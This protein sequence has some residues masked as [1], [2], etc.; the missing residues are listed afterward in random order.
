MFISHL[1]AIFILFYNHLNRISSYFAFSLQ[2]KYA[3]I[4]LSLF[5]AIIAALSKKHVYLLKGHHI[6]CSLFTWLVHLND[7]LSPSPVSNGKNPAT[8]L[9]SQ[10]QFTFRIVHLLSPFLLLFPNLSYHQ[11]HITTKL[12]KSN[13]SR[14]RIKS[15]NHLSFFSFLNPPDP[16]IPNQ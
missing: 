6:T 11:H 2:T 5:P 14:N 12:N 13:R 9:M 3:Y 10:S 7:K 15:K 4:F 8:W 1:P 16:N